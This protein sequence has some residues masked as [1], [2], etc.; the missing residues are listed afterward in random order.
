MSFNRGLLDSYP[1]SELCQFCTYMRPSSGLSES[2]YLI[3]L[4]AR[5]L[6]NS[7]THIEELREEVAKKDEHIEALTIDLYNLK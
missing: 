3:N 2:E 1:D 6:E 5:R 4:L 7:A